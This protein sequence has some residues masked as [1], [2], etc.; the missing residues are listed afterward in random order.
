MCGSLSLSTGHA[1]HFL[2]PCPFCSV[3]QAFTCSQLKGRM[4]HRRGKKGA[5]TGSRVSEAQA[6]GRGEVPRAPF[7]PDR[8]SLRSKGEGEPWTSE[9]CGWQG[10]LAREAAGTEG[11]RAAR[12]PVSR[13]PQP[14]PRRISGGPVCGSRLG[15]E[16][17]R[18]CL[19][20]APRRAAERAGD[21]RFHPRAPP[22]SALRADRPQPAAP[23]PSGGHPAIQQHRHSVYLRWWP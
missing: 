8:G 5:P 1:G 12:R 20:S 11:A 7:G 15:G 2:L 16:W 9:G 3:I 6:A 13:A 18:L 23:H 19:R 14:P 17:G 4:T 22:T 10:W 21:L